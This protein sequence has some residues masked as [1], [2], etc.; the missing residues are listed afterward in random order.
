MTLDKTICKW[1]K[2]L[3]NSIPPSW[4]YTE[5]DGSLWRVTMITPGDTFYEKIHD[6]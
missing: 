6:R 5:K 4:E 2:K 3:W 1:F